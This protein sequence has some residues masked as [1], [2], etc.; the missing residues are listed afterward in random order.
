M[1][2][3]VSGWNN[4]T[5][6]NIFLKRNINLKDIKRLSNG[7]FITSRKYYY[8]NKTDK[9]KYQSMTSSYRQASFDLFEAY[10]MVNNELVPVGQLSRDIAS[11]YQPS[12][13]QLDYDR[14]FI[15]KA[16]GRLNKVNNM[17]DNALNDY[18]KQWG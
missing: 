5:E 4:K 12:H 6:S 8:S 11:E 17:A 13:R 18:I 1:K 9:I 7:L 14:D 2:L 16:N 3:L 10:I 15:S